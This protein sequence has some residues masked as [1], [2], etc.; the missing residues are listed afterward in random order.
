VAHRWLWSG[1]NRSPADQVWTRTWWLAYQSDALTSAIGACVLADC[2][3][4]PGDRGPDQGSCR[5]IRRPHASV[6]A[7]PG[8]GA[9]LTR[10]T[11]WSNPH[12]SGTRALRSTR[13][14][15]AAAAPHNP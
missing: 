6:K 13:I 8:V 9:E 1:H 4:R 3:Y 14:D 12:M 10:E 2:S 15:G 7:S 5:L 11:G